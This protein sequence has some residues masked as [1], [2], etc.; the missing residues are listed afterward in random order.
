[1][2][3]ESPLVISCLDGMLTEVSGR[4]FEGEV[5]DLGVLNEVIEIEVGRWKG[6]KVLV[7]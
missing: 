7:M 3:D 6:R 1:M 2:R 5:D 4:F